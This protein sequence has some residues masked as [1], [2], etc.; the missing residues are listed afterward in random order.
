MKNTIFILH[1]SHFIL[2]FV[3]GR[4]GFEPAKAY[5]SGV[6]V[7][8]IWPL[9]NRPTKPGADDRNRTDNLRFTKPLLCQL[10][11]VGAPNT[12]SV[13]TAG[14]TIARV[15]TLVKRDRGSC[16]RL[17]KGARPPI[18]DVRTSE[19]C[20]KAFPS[21]PHG[22]RCYSSLGGR[23]MPRS[24]SAATSRSRSSGATRTTAADGR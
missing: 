22:R 14:V 1:P 23:A 16:R 2:P 4:A 24:R 11:Y 9:W 8:P 13:R 17:W 7:R 20:V 3:V 19:R 21:F 18:I 5:A 10:S 6:T 15:P 12:L